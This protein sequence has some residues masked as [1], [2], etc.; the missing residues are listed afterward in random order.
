MTNRDKAKLQRIVFVFFGLAAAAALMVLCAVLLRSS[1]YGAN[2]VPQS[3]AV[4]LETGAAQEP[5]AEPDYS[6]ELAAV[7]FTGSL[8]PGSMLGSNTFGT[9]NKHVQENGPE[10]FLQDLSGYLKEDCLTVSLCDA[11]LSDSDSLKP[12]EKTVPAWSRGP[13]TNVDIFKKGG[14]DLLSVASS[15]IHDYGAEGFDDTV[16]AIF[17][18]GLAVIPENDYV[19]FEF[20]GM[21]VAVISGV[22]GENDGAVRELAAKAAADCDLV[23]VYMSDTGAG[24]QPSAEK[25][26][27]FRS[28]IDAGADLVA[29]TNGMNLQPVEEY[30]GGYIAYSLGCL[31]DGMNRYGE[32]YS[33]I[34]RCEL[35]K[36]SGGEIEKVFGII[37]LVTYTSE[38]QWR[39]Q[40]LTEIEM[41]TRVNAFLSGE[42][43]YLE[44]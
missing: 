41:L 40:V 29:G 16:R 18:N 17:T 11:V 34:L 27:A 9:F 28:F 12:A 42:R 10:F 15:R 6:Y 31:I 4:P 19:R 24:Y 13:V 14:I 30:N 26:E 2:I 36:S 1:N 38:S 43:E 44:G 20:S 37:P 22:L 23:A 21:S 5:V 39:P 3:R 33:A 7:S 8:T 25:T 32:R 35:R